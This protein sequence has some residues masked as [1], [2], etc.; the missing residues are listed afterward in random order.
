MSANFKTILLSL[1]IALSAALASACADD[2]SSDSPSDHNNGSDD[3]GSDDTNVVPPIAG[4]DGEQGASFDSPLVDDTDFP[5]DTEIIGQ[6]AQRDG[7]ASSLLFDRLYPTSDQPQSWD[8]CHFATPQFWASSETDAE[9]LIYYASDQVSA[10]DADTLEEVFSV[11]LPA[12]EG[13]R[14]LVVGEPIA[15]GHRLVVVYHTTDADLDKRGVNSVRSSQLVAVI[16]LDEGA[17]DDDFELLWLDADFTD[18]MGRSYG[19]QSSNALGR[20]RLTH[21]PGGPGELGTVYPSYGNARDIQP[22]H[23]FLFQI[24]L[25]AWLAE[26]ADAAVTH[27]LSTTN[28]ADCGP[29]GRSGSRERICGGGLWSPTGNLESTYDGESVL[30]LPAGNGRLDL[31]KEAYANTLMRYFPGQDFDPGCDETLC[32]E[33]DVDDPSR[34][35]M[36]SCEHMFIPRM[37]E[38]EDY[39]QPATGHCEGLTMLECWETLDYVGGSS[40]ARV[41]FDDGTHVY[42]YP[43]KDGAMYLVDGQHMGIQHDRMQLAENCGTET[44]PCVWDWAGMIIAQPTVHYTPDG[45]LLLV[46]T[47]ITDDEQPAGL[48]AVR[49]IQ[50]GDGYSFAMAWRVPDSGSAAAINRFRRHPSNVEVYDSAISPLAMFVE[51]MRDKSEGRLITVNAADGRLLTDFDL[52]GPGVRFTRPLIVGDRVH[53][54]H[55]LTDDGPAWRE[56]WSLSAGD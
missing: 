51:V 12:P 49:V 30:I 56:S 1:V 39:P 17:V 10:F 41:D 36:E 37:P 25:D 20:A 19:F 50:E 35:C 31:A 14:A 46:P 7:S 24:D 44:S 28:E 29:A 53:L 21:F 40:P 42:A 34:E 47:F 11:T 52:T 6:F 32:A 54:V 22:W 16:D 18:F 13:E 9:L 48:Q 45:P 27:A 15:V 55:C 4:P 23:G 38:G 33:F 8:A 2:S 3:N 5:L 43:T 26:G